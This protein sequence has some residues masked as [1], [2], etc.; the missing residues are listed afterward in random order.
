MLSAGKMNKLYEQILTIS[1]Q[2]GES[3][4]SSNP[5]ILLLSCGGGGGGFFLACEDFGRRLAH[6]IPAY[7]FFFLKWRLACAHKFHT[8]CQNQS[9]VAQRT[10][11]TV[12]ECS[13]LSC[14]SLQLLTKYVDTVNVKKKKSKGIHGQNWVLLLLLD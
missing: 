1:Q 9:T 7:A 13:L 4:A 2:N 8:L 14:K 12:A 11:T 6:P 3:P 5:N 10:E